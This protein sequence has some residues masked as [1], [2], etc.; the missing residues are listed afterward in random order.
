MFHFVS[1]RNTRS[2]IHAIYFSRG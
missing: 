2:C 1:V